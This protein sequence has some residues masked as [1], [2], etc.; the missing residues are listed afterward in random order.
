MFLAAHA[1]IGIGSRCAGIAQWEE[2]IGSESQ[3]L[4]DFV[5]DAKTPVLFA[6]GHDGSE[7]LKQGE[8]DQ[9]VDSCACQAHFS[10]GSPK[11]GQTFHNPGPWKD[12]Q[13]TIRHTVS[14]F[15][16]TPAEAQSCP[17]KLLCVL[18]M[19]FATKRVINH[20]LRRC[21]YPGIFLPCQTWEVVIFVLIINYLRHARAC[22]GHPGAVYACR[23]GRQKRFFQ[24]LSSERE[25]LSKKHTTQIKPAVEH[26]R[27]PKPPHPWPWIAGTSPAMTFSCGLSIG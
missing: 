26:H 21:L 5:P 7:G 24:A 13:H 6:R 3:F 25:L 27:P 2:R 17:I 16:V 15:L 12:D 18:R 20:M 14:I 9:I 1:P 19:I 10:L 22:P 4:G 23:S 11:N 8:Y